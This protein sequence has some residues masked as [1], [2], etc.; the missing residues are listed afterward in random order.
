[1]LYI[2]SPYFRAD[3][4]CVLQASVMPLSSGNEPTIYWI[5]F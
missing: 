3:G 5:F 1:M 4:S 2:L